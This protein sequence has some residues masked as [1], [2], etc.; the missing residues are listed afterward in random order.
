MVELSI[1][2]SYLPVTLTRLKKF[3]N[4]KLETTDKKNEEKFVNWFLCTAGA[5]F[6]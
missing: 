6:W 3:E 1:V 5:A 4:F 2:Y